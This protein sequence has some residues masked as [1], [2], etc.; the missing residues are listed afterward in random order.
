[1]TRTEVVPNTTKADDTIVHIV[2]SICV[3]TNQYYA[4][5]DQR[6]TSNTTATTTT[7]SDRSDTQTQSIVDPLQQPIPSPTT[8]D[9]TQSP[10]TPT[11]IYMIDN[12]IYPALTGMGSAEILQLSDQFAQRCRSVLF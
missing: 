10:P 9:L 3:D 7:T 2:E 12:T 8:F 11:S 6:N 4:R 1:M 5:V